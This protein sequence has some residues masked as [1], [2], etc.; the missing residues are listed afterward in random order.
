MIKVLIKLGVFKVNEND[1]IQRIIKGISNLLVSIAAGKNAVESCIDESTNRVV[2]SEDKL[3]EIM[4]KR[5]MNEG[6]INEA[7]DMLFEEIETN[8]SAKNLET[9]LYFYKELN[10]WDEK[11]LSKYNFSKREIVEGLKEVKKLYENNKET[12]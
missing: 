3:L 11:R 2:I 9:A 4:I 7:E 12:L 8:R 1:Y 6:K 5:Y 10:E